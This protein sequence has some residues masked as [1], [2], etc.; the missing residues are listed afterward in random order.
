MGLAPQVCAGK[1]PLCYI[2]VWECLFPQIFICGCIVRV[3]RWVRVKCLMICISCMSVSR[4][5]I[6]VW[7]WGLGFQQEME[8]PLWR[9]P[10]TLFK[11]PSQ[12]SHSWGGGGWVA[13]WSLVVSCCVVDFTGIFLLPGWLKEVSKWTKFQSYLGIKLVPGTEHQGYIRFG[14]LCN[15]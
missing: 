4:W 6:S 1:F 5:V 3:C 14:E 7:S 15:S 10:C 2:C 11:P 9:D 8:L 12:P 13:C